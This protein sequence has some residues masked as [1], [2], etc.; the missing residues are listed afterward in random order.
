MQNSTLLNAK[1]NVY[2]QNGE[3]GVIELLID[4]LDI[5]EGSFCEFGAWDGQ[6][7]S[8]TFN[9]L[10]NKNWRGVYI[11]GDSN[12]YQDLIKL[13]DEYGGRI[14]TI[15]AYVD[16]KDENKLDNLLKNTFLEKNFDLLSID[17]DGMD[18]HIW[19]ALTEYKPKLVII[20]VNSNLRPGDMTIQSKENSK[21]VTGSSFSAICELGIKKGYYPLIH[22]G[23]VFLGEF[24]FLKEKNYTTNT[25]INSLF[26]W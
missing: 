2:S 18:Y 6:Y 11:E 1:R 26:N 13:K 24:N 22:F 25:D 16:Y 14:E 21:I 17:V 3:D 10:K 19:E 4:S 12:K 8:N 9:L 15:N 23:N 5:K 7:L 20:E